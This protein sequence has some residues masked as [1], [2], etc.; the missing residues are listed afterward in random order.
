MSDAAAS[1]PAPRSPPRPCRWRPPPRWTRATR[2]GGLLLGVAL[3]VAMILIAA[4]AAKVA[5]Y[6]P[7]AR[8]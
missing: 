4:F 6:D 2:S 5:P 1:P 3:V 8:T 7:D